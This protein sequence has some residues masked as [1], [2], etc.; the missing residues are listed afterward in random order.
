MLLVLSYIQ[1]LCLKEME[2]SR[3]SVLLEEEIPGR[4]MIGASIPTRL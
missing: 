4:A 1:K 2:H 3:K